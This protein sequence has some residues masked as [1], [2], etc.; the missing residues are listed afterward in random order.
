MRR[1]SLFLVLALAACA[2]PPSKEDVDRAILELR[3]T[4]SS[5][6]QPIE[7]EMRDLADQLL[8][9]QEHQ[10]AVLNVGA[11]ALTSRIHAIRAARE[12]IDIQTFL[13][14][15]DDSG[16]LLF[17]E[18]TLA[19]RRGVRVRL[20]VD[21]MGTGATDGLP[22]AVLIHENLEIRI[23]NPTANLN[24]VSNR[25]KL[26]TAT[27]SFPLLNH[28]MH[29]KVVVVD[30]CIGIVGGR[31]VQDRYFDLDPEFDYIDRDVLVLG[32]VVAE[33][34]R[35]FEE[36]WTH[37]HAVPAQYLYDVRTKVA[38]YLEEQDLPELEPDDYARL[39]WAVGLA[40]QYDADAVMP[41]SPLM[42]ADEVRF[43]ADPAGKRDA[44]GALVGNMGLDSVLRDVAEDYVLIQSNYCVF[45]GG[46][47]YRLKRLFEEK[48]E[49]EV[50]YQ[51]N[52]RAAAG[53]G[54]CWAIYRKQRMAMMLRGLRLYELRPFPGDVR[55]FNAR[56]DELVSEDAALGES[57][58][59]YEGLID[60]PGYGP[61][62]AIHAKTMVVD[63]KAVMIGS[64]N[65]DPRSEVHNTEAS[66]VIFDEE[67]AQSL[68]A[69]LRLAM[70]NQN[71]WRVA[72]DPKLPVWRDFTNLIAHMS[73]ALPTLDVWPS[74]YATNFELREGAESVPVDDPRFYE[75]YR[76]VG[77]FPEVESGWKRF[78][79][80]LMSAFGGFASGLL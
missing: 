66:V 26:F 67:V 74:Y 12:S 49:L 69:E 51:T 42:Q 59:P 36:Y 39:T 80:W 2:V 61:Q 32:P 45:S 41:H 11:D 8:A 57:V 5:G 71:S 6:E 48:P 22:E 37:R 28:R 79:T 19:A 63:G 44:E 33:M 64:H 9:A 17:Q 14:A 68:E 24:A 72:P 40:N 4:S 65:F 15:P 78:T 16:D 46:Q 29:N 58:E 70:A 52:S 56:Y 30:G 76:D 35:S 21:H 27:H 77:S 53:C 10:V 31:N 60:L 7:S 3:D 13:W 25:K 23:Y 73:R 50:H 55:H 43:F 47:F 34:D 20:L 54:Y 62:T 18:L 1:A 38:D 75:N